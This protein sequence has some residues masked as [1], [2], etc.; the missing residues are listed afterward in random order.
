MK[1]NSRLAAVFLDRDGTLIEDRGNLASPVEIELFPDTVAA[2]QSLQPYFQLF[3]VSNQSGVGE[4]AISIEDVDRVNGSLSLMLANHGIQLN[5]M[6]VCPHRRADN[7]VCRKPKPHFLHLAE[8]QF[9]IDL[10]RSFV[11]GDH[12]HDV[13]LATNAGARGVYVT[14]GHGRKHLGELPPGEPVVTGIG[15]AAAWILARRADAVQVA[16]TI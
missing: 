16:D 10:K 14:T 11:V 1:R 15:E 12:P 6:Y 3:I 9:G 8:R 13:I 5:A 7:C 4:G 2:L